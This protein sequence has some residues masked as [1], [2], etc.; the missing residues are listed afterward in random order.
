MDTEDL[1]NQRRFHHARRE[2]TDGPHGVLV[3]GVDLRRLDCS[4]RGDDLPGDGLER[5]AAPAG[6]KYA[7][8]LS[9][10]G[11]G[12]RAADR[13]STAVPT[14]LIK[15]TVRSALINR[16]LKTGDFVLTFGMRGSGP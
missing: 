6:E 13:T 14:R 3:E 9:S 15:A 11:T 5:R 7:C 4:T 12:D 8:T 1:V 2:H 10:E 16:L